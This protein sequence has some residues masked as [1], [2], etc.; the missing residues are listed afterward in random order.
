M[1]I[2]LSRVSDKQLQEEMQRRARE[3]SIY[4]RPEQLPPDA[5]IFGPL[6]RVC[7]NYIRD[8]DEKGWADEN[9]E[10]YI[11]EAALKAVY[12]Q[13]VLDWIRRATR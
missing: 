7:E 13:E 5:Q 9:Y 4:P 12:G 3:A 2:D 6:Q 10:G 1:M 8:L 11:A